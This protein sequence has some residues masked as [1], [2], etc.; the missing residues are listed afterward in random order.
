MEI[1]QSNIADFIGKYYEPVSEELMEL[2]AF[3]EER[4]IPVIR[5][6]TENFFNVLFSVYQPASI[7]EI[8]TAIGYSSMYFAVKCP[9]SSVF[10]IE[11]DGKVF[12]A[13]EKNISGFGLNNRISMFLGDGEEVTDRLKDEN[14]KFDL[15]FIDAAKSHYKRFLDSVMSIAED[16]ALIISD[17]IF[18]RGTTINEKI[19]PTRK[20]RTNIRRM[21]EYIEYITSH[22]SLETM[23][24]NV[25]DGLAVSRYTG[26]TI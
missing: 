25:G 24:L 12:D 16:G 18:Q 22:P 13:A 17:D 23:L 26:N 11:R 6:E 3:A 4:Y 21:Q 8:G 10:T 14:R 1:S 7:L 2:R 9:G 5:R 19:D 15:I 20:H